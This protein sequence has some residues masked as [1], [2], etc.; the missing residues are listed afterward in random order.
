MA[1]RRVREGEKPSGVIASY[2][3][4]RTSIY[5]WLRAERLKIRAEGSSVL[6][7]PAEYRKTGYARVK[8]CAERY[9]LPCHICGCKNCDITVEKRGL[10]RQVAG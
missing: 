10:G 9:A 3:L 4:C 2:G 6:A 7:L 8:A 1:C 5:R